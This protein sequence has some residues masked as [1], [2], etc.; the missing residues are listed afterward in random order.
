MTES[1]EQRKSKSQRK[2]EALAL[3][4]IAESLIAL[5]PS[6]LARIPMG[7]ELD[8]A[9][10]AARGL[11][12][13]ALRRQIRFIARLLREDDSDSIAQALDTVRYPGRREAARHRR[14]ERLRDA[15]VRGEVSLDAV[16]EAAPELDFQRLRHLVAAAQRERD[17]ASGS[18]QGNARRNTQGNA[19]G[20]ASERRLFRFLRD[21]GPE[22][23]NVSG[24]DASARR[25]AQ[26]R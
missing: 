24:G 19:R 8:A 17:N 10:T 12:R 9:I 5:A 7:A 11:Q 15:M 13:V 22:G 1:S 4:A 26:D 2:R 20:S 3:Q 14:I 23:L 16:R 25:P 21:C 18:A 6:D